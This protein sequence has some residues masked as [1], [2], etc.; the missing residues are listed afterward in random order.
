MKKPKNGIKN[1]AVKDLEDIDS[2]SKL[3]MSFSMYIDLKNKDPKDLTIDEKLELGFL[4]NEVKQM[5]L[6]INLI[7]SPFRNIPT[8]KNNLFTSVFNNTPLNPSSQTTNHKSIS[9][10]NIQTKNIIDH[11]KS[12]P[13]VAN[14]EEQIRQND[15]LQSLIDITEANNKN[16]EFKNLIRPTYNRN[17][18]TLIFCNKP[19]NV[20]NGKDY[21]LLCDSMFRNSMPVTNPPLIGDL[22]HKWNEPD[23]KNSKRVRNAVSNFNKYIATHT[24]VRDLFCVKDLYVKFD[25]KYI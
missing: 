8:V 24:T 20:S 19:I 21:S 16:L 22:L 6:K 9:S 4:D 18:K 13:S 3:P 5:M 15:L 1:D 10:P 25:S 7:L 2:K 23:H 14:S 12:S 11:I 17:T